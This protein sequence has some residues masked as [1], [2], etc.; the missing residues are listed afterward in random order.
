MKIAI[1]DDDPNDIKQLKHYVLNHDNSHI[2][3]EFTGAIQLL[4]K[5]SDGEDFDLLFLDI[6]M[7]DGNGWEIAKELK[8][9]KSKVYIAMITVLGEYIFECFD[10]V[11]WFAPKP[12]NCDRIF[13]ILNN[14]EEKLYPKTFS[15]INDRIQTYLNANEIIYLEVRRNN[16]LINTTKKTYSVRMTLKNAQTMLSECKQFVQIH[17]SYVL[18]L[19]YYEA[20]VS[21]EI[22]L[23]TGT[24][25]AL[26]RTY[27]K[28]FFEALS[29][30]IREV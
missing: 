9:R 20:L 26:T 1:C 10:R 15:F 27:R 17:N 12:Y 8:E 2:I 28:H 16:L 22:I 3:Y 13:Q 29:E 24:K 25:L 6:Q 30:Y 7:P 4:K 14:A 18:N 23:K 11:D 5:L 21:S 19:D